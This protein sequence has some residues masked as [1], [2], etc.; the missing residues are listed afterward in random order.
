MEKIVRVPLEDVEGFKAGDLVRIHGVV[1]TLRDASH[2]RLKELYDKGEEFPFPTKG[3]VIYYSAPTPPRAGRPFGALG[4]T[5]ARRMDVYVPMLLEKGIKG[6][7]GKG[8]RGE[9]VRE[10]LARYKAVYFLAVGGAG[11]Y[12]GGFV[13]KARVVAFEDLGPEAI[14]EVELE[15]LPCIVAID[16]TGATIFSF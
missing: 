16:P 9:E 14:Y 6:M 12:L 8:K 11:A 1:Y 2:R 7:I 4:P 13:R 10:A 5:T 15:G 3:S